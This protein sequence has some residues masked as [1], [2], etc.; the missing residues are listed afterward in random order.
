MA[1]QEKKA[2]SA[3]KGPKKVQTIEQ[4]KAMGTRG[5]LVILSRLAYSLGSQAN[6]AGSKWAGRKKE[7]VAGTFYQKVGPKGAVLTVSED[8]DAFKNA[9]AAGRS[10][11]SDI[12]SGKY[13]SAV[14]KFL[15]AVI[16]IN[17]GGTGTRT[18]DFGMAADLKL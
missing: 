8:S 2:A 1:K 18:R 5:N 3:A 9:L 14:A 13:T 12:A 7:A 11:K 16:A 15:D 4:L 6:F 17:V 10:A